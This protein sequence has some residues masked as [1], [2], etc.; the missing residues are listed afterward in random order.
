MATMSM[1]IRALPTD[2]TKSTHQ[3]RQQASAD[4]DEELDLGGVSTAELVV[5]KAVT[6]D[7]QVD[8]DYSTSFDANIEIP[9]GE[10]AVFKPVGT[11]R[12]KNKNAGE[13]CTYEYLVVGT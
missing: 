3:Y 7:L 8:A 10:M 13:Q 4:S 2:P 9:E 6:N 5:I 11:V 1:T 12:V